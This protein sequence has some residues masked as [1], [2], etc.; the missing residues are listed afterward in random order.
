MGLDVDNKDG[1]T[2][3]DD[4]EKEGLL[5]KTITKRS[6]LDEFEQLNI[7]KAV[8]WTMKRKF[9]AEDIL[10]EA[11]M[12]ELHRRM[13]GDVWKWAGEFRKTNKNLG[14]DKLQ[15]AVELRTLVDNCKHW[16]AQEVFGTDETAI[17]FKHRIVSIHCFANGNGRHSRLIAD[18]I[19]E[20]IFKQPVFSWGA[21]SV[22]KQGEARKAYLQAIK[23]ADA[24]NFEELVRFARS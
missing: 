19:V 2:A 21:A 22:S 9:K 13:Y 12:K 10:S 6:E 1:Q 18:V 23:K 24:G 5:I 15:I 7:E 14:V 11:F 20:H 16:I 17:H 3:L 8:L 4:D